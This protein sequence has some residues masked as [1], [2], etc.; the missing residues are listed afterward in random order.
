MAIT[1]WRS[2]LAPSRRASASDRG[3]LLPRCHHPCTRQGDP[4]QPWIRPVPSDSAGP[5]SSW[6]AA[7]GAEEFCRGAGA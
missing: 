5:T 2:W 3:T 7:G 6:M 1:V 4:G